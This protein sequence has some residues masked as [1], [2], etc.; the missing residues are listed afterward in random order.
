MYFFNYPWSFTKKYQHWFVLS[1]LKHWDI[2][3]KVK[4]DGNGL[5]TDLHLHPESQQLISA[6]PMNL[7]PHLWFAV[8]PDQITSDPAH[9]RWKYLLKTSAA[10]IKPS[11]TCDTRILPAPK[12]WKSSLAKVHCSDD[13]FSININVFK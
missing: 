10:A 2:L 13:L 3:R 12:I 7:H 5:S 11:A 1:L 9:L 4:R 6:F 8:S